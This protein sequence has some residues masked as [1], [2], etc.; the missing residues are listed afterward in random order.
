LL[1]LDALE[2]PPNGGG[3]PIDRLSAMEMSRIHRLKM[4]GFEHATWMVPTPSRGGAATHVMGI[5]LPHEA[6][7]AL[8]QPFLDAGLDVEGITP[9]MPSMARLTGIL[10]AM[11]AD[12]LHYLVDIGW[13]GARLMVVRNATL[14]FSRTLHDASIG[15]LVQD[16][17]ERLSLSTVAAAELITSAGISSISSDIPAAAQEAVSRAIMSMLQVIVAEQRKT[18]NYLSH[19]YHEFQQGRLAVF[20]G[21]ASIPGVAEVLEKETGHK[22]ILFHKRMPTEGGVAGI[23]GTSVTALALALDASEVLS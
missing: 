3:L 13:S 11:E 8:V 6:A 18:R 20:G 10:P 4:E 9:V 17:A 7:D 5:A 1:K 15:K 12:H 22:V 23:D 2:L 14:L 21:G 19:R 16:I